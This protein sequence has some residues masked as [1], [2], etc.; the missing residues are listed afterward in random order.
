MSRLRNFDA[1]SGLLAAAFALGVAELMAG[2][3]G[4]NSLIV[5]VGDVFVDYTPGPIVKATIEALGTNDKP[6]LLLSVVVISLLLE[7]GRAHV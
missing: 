5:A 4:A 2:I 6:A 3:T 1:L 7:I